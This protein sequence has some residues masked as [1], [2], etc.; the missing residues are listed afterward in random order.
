MGK[1][2]TLVHVNDVNFEEEVL[3]S[4]K[5]VLVDFWAPWC[6]PC[7][8]MGQIVEEL[9]KRYKENT[10]IAKLNV[11][12]GPQSANKYGIRATPTLML[13]KNGEVQDTIVGLAPKD[14]VEDIIKKSL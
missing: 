6:G 7:L 8:P 5:L 14:R 2:G 3:N 4:E 12:D 10:K 13:F 1:E 11:D 9:A